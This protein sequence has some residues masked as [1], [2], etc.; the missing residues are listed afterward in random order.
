MRLFM[1]TMSKMQKKI[2]EARN[3]SIKIISA[4]PECN[5][6][7]VEL[8]ARKATEIGIRENEASK[9]KSSEISNAY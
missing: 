1:P 6:T 4:N 9:S 8:K 7:L 5:S 2:G 3:P